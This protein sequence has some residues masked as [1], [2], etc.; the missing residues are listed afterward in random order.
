MELT[1][2]MNSSL[3]MRNDYSEESLFEDGLCF[4][5]CGFIMDG[6]SCCSFELW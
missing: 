2:T 6:R 5:R 3:A 4:I 1:C